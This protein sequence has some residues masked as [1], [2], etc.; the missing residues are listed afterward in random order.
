[1]RHGGF[2][3]EPGKPNRDV[4]M[5]SIVHCWQSASGIKQKCEKG[6]PGRMHGTV[7][8]SATSLSIGRWTRCFGPMHLKSK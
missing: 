7:L 4:H 6:V 5:G 1:M 8:Q 2:F 3:V